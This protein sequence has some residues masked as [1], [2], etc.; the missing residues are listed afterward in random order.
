[1]MLFHIFEVRSEAHIWLIE[2]HKSI[3]KFIFHIKKRSSVSGIQRMGSSKLV[4]NAWLQQVTAAEYRSNK[5]QL[6]SMALTSH[7]H[8][9]GPSNHTW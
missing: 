8:S 6:P 1:M 9:L 3:L 4:T 2:L 7:R 5:S